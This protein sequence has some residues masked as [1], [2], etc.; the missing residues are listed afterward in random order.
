MK[1]FDRTGRFFAY[2]ILAAAFTVFG[3]KSNQSSQNAPT[4]PSDQSSTQPAADQGQQSGDPA[5]ANVV[6]ISN[7]TTGP[8]A[9][10]GESAPSGEAAPSGQA[11]PSGGSDQ[12][13]PDQY[14]EDNGYGEQPE[15]YAQQPPPQLP[16]YEQPPCPE[17]GDIWTPGH[18]AWAP[19]GYYWVPGAWVRAPY[20]GALWTPP[21]WGYRG[22]H[23]AYYRGYWGRH[24]GYYGGIN[25]G[26]G[27]GGFGYQGGYWRGNQFEYNTSV[28]RVNTAVIRNVYNYHITNVTVTRVSYNGPG[29]VRYRPR[30]AEVMAIREE[31]T[32][33]MTTQVQLRQQAQTNRAMFYNTNRGRPATLVAARPLP[34]DRNVRPP[35]QVN[36]ARGER[37]P[38][39]RAIQEQQ[40]AAAPV[41]PE[42]H[43]APERPQ[44]QRPESR[45]AGRPQAAQPQRP[46]SRP[47]GRPQA[48]QPQ[49]PESRPAERPQVA[50]PQRPESRPAERPQ[51]A[52]P[53]RP[54][55]QHATPQRP[56][57]QQEHSRP[58][59]EHQATPEHA[60]PKEQTH[61]TEAKKP[62]PQKKKPEDRKPE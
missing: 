27:Y 48:A 22:G 8:A 43:P 6:P 40:H 54:E 11:A 53:Q 38:A 23:Y 35:A 41:R 59:L 12:Y 44:V 3:C 42:A 57:P 19:A 37:P 36:Y 21:Y 55:A 34:A 45:P 61:P 5:N 15:T 32:P 51:A 25:Y 7:T 17:E 1:E 2:L 16:D 31:H 58:A 13:S 46:E 49:R 29:G 30:P 26:F 20:E 33:P 14:N 52:Q 62:E 9:S 24:I 47:A 50:Q 39:P 4:N 56:A 18:W 28:N 10:S 60:A